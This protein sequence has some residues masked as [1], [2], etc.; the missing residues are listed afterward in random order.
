MPGGRE[1]GAAEVVW[2]VIL[3]FLSLRVYNRKSYSPPAAALAR[4]SLITPSFLASSA[5][6]VRN[7]EL[8]LVSRVARSASQ[9]ARCGKCVHERDDGER[10]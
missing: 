9:A 2:R 3:I 8:M 10:G 7:R 5:L 6:A 1:R 4:A